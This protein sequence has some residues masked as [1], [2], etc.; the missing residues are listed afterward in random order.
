[1]NL[2]NMQL[3]KVNDRKQ[4]STIKQTSLKLKLLNTIE[5][6][7]KEYGYKFQSYEVDNVLL[8]M[9]KRNHESYLITK[10]GYDT[11]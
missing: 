6:F 4:E 3:P 5:E 2:D 7:E 11:I 10:F 1:M 9:I 8:E